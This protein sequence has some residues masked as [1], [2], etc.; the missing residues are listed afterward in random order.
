M[1]YKQ[2]VE[3]Y[4]DLEKTTKRLEKTK[5]ISNFLEKCSSDEL[6]EIV[7][8]IQGRIF[9]EWDERETGMSSMLIIKVLTSVTGLSKRKIESIWRKKGD[10]GL[11]AEEIVSK[12]KQS[13]LTFK[14][15]TVKKVFDNIRK[16]NEMTGQGTVNRKVQ[17]VAELIGN[18]SPK[19]AKFIVKTIL[20]ELRVGIAYGTIRDAVIQAFLPKVIGIN[21]GLKFKEAVKKK[22]DK[23]LKVKSI[24]DLKNIKKYRFILAENEKT[25]RE[26]Y[27]YFVDLTQN[28]YDISSDFGE[29]AEKLSREG[30]EGLKNIGIKVGIPIN[31]MLPIKVDGIDEGIKSVGSP[32]LA[33]YKLDGFRCVTGYVP[34]YCLDKGYISIKDLKEGDKVLTHRGNFKKIIRLNKRVIDKGERLFELQMFFGEKI[35][36]SE[37]HRI[38]V[39][40]NNK[41]KWIPVEKINKKDF[42]VFPIPKIRKLSKLKKYLV[43]SD[44]SGYSKKIKVDSFFF[45][46]L[47]FWIGDGFTNN[48][49]NTERIG[50]LFNRKKEY[51]LCNY[52]YKGIKEKFGI[53]NVTKSIQKN[54]INLYFR[55]KPFRIWLSQNFREEWRGKKIPLWFLGIN[56]KQF[57]S[58]IQGYLESDGYVDSIGR[59]SITTKE[60]DIAM[61]I[62]LLALKFKKVYGISKFRVDG[63]TY[64][65]IIIP[66]TNKYYKIVQNEVYV[67]ILRL[68]ELKKRDPRTKL[69]NLEVEG[70]RSYCT[71]FV[72]LHNCQ[73]HKK[74]DEIK[75][76]TRGLENVTKQFSELVGLIKSQI[77]GKSFIIDSEVVGYDQKTKKYLPFQFIS[78]RIKRKY[79][80]ESKA[81]EVPVEINVFDV[82][83]YNGK[84]VIRLSQKERRKLLEKIVKEKAGKLV[85]TKKIITSDKNKISRFYK[86]SLEKGNEGLILKNLEKVYT[87]G[88][89]VGGWVKLKPV[90]ESLDLVI[91]KATYGEGKRAHLLS[92][93]TLAC[94]DEDRYLECGMMGTGIKEKGEGVTFK[95]LT[96]LLKPLIISEKGRVVNIKP[97]IIVEVSYE[98]IQKSP[99]YNSGYALR[100]PRLIRLRN[101]K[102]TK[103]VS[104][105][106]FI[107]NIYKRQK[108]LR[109]L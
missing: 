20:D 43:L 44:D 72:S 68:N 6:K 64:Y 35:K 61:L 19:E 21:T 65:K 36:I 52:Y 60:R 57:N 42:L 51:K 58:F 94:K 79:K 7:Y 75:F 29:I 31:P 77:K 49:H 34:I 39:L 16:L 46:F 8:L 18:A 102:S 23:V 88:R 83:Y 41:K 5:I 107:K 24:K 12:N 48:Y 89:K 80:I 82:M 78:Q 3:V 108:E 25:A 105:I 93:F 87:P 74:G 62:Q 66:K 103:D 86:E 109:S 1:Q 56:E 104:N 73:I 95:E 81:K 2:L 71:S 47:G 27:N 91:V 11:V 55:D 85:L 4:E 54:L 32:L 40:R 9:P 59:T 101:D 106:D 26:V 100:F 53:K 13:K 99:T 67:K 90:L 84:N 45:R 22:Y 92:S 17:L 50:L 97:K 70:D 33:D 15:L 30:L 38:L 14:E 96:K 63:K 69:Y 10:L 37:K 28:T 76:F 98:E